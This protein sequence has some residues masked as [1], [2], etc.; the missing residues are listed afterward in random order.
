[1]RIFPISNWSE[2]DIWR[3][4]EAESLALPSIYF[5][6]NRK[7]VRREGKL[8]P[9]HPYLKVDSQETI[10]ELRVRFRT[11]G[12]MTC[13]AAVSSSAQDPTSIINELQSSTI[14]ERGE[15]RI[16][17]AFSESAMEERKAEGYF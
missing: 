4:I 11:V 12:D 13:T 16:D 1:M 7:V 17:D 8:V 2:L 15:T 6:H 10:V 14:S 5:A 3:Y 9:V